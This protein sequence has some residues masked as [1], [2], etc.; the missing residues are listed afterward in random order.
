MKEFKSDNEFDKL[1]QDSLKDDSIDPPDKVWENIE[2]RLDNESNKPKFI[3][4]LSLFIGIVLIGTISFLAL[5]KS[6][7]VG[8]VTEKTNINSD[9]K[10]NKK[11]SKKIDNKQLANKENPAIE[12]ISEEKNNEKESKKTDSRQLVNKENSTIENS[13]AAT[14][15]AIT[16]ASEEKNNKKEKSKQSTNKEKPT[17]TNSDA[18]TKPVITKASEEKD[19]KEEN[20]KQSTNKENSA[21][22]SDASSKPAIAKTTDEKLKT[23]KKENSNQSVKTNN[24]NPVESK[25][26]IADTASTLSA[27]LTKSQQNKIIKKDSLLA[28]DSVKTKTDTLPK[29]NIVKDDAPKINKDSATQKPVDPFPIATIYGF[30]SPDYFYSQISSSQTGFNPAT[31]KQSMRFS[32]GVKVEY[33]PIR[34]IG[35]QIGCAYSEMRQSKEESLLKFYKYIESPYPIYSSL[36]EMLVDPAIMKDGFYMAAPI[37]SFKFNTTYT[38]TVKFLNVPV[39]VKLNLLKNRFNVYVNAGLNTQIVLMQRSTLNLIK[40]NFTNTIVYNDVKV[41]RFNYSF[42][43]GLGAEFKI[44]KRLGIFIEPGIRYCLN[45]QSKVPDIKNKPIVMGGNGGICIYL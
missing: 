25:K 8:S 20:S 10:N 31:E 15:P 21:I 12:K 7:P 9:E 11:E 1:F 6:K 14:K 23:E 43:F 18:A 40:E 44:Y 38:Q 5:E 16:K 26:I 22:N 37:D 42:L 32:T 34:M 2:S 35:I 3:F 4:W 28:K 45:N 33:R 17:T 27:A 41:N 30:Y 19:N 36:G 29:K 24:E 13:D 39:N